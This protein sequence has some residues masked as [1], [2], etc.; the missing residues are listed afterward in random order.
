MRWKDKALG[1]CKRFG[2]PAKFAAK[3]TLGTLLPSSP[4]V[5]ERV[6]GV[7]DCV[8]E[9]AKDNLEF[10]AAQMPAA[11]IDDVLATAQAAA[12]DLP[13]AEKTLARAGRLR[14]ADAELADLHR[15]V[16]VV[17]RDATPSQSPSA[18]ACESGRCA[19]RLAFAA[20]ARQ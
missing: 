3:L 11:S 8:H 9:I 5:V 16:T 6:C 4:A 13:A 20:D 12:Q 15:R 17:S 2:A 10:D 19:G 1:L 7:L 14:P 18:T